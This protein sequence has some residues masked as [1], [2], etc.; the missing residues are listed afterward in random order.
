MA[1][2]VV[3]SLHQLV[4]RGPDSPTKSESCAVIH[5]LLAPPANPRTFRGRE[6][7]ASIR[8][9]VR[10][11]FPQGEIMEPENRLKREDLKRLGNY[12]ESRDDPDPEELSPKD[13]FQQVSN[14][15]LCMS[16]DLVDK[17][18]FW[19]KESLT[20]SEEDVKKRIPH[21]AKCLQRLKVA[22]LEFSDTEL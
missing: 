4:L 19:E 10:G 20:L 5:M 3:A 21:I 6:S 9:A 16:Y 17:I 8:M 14:I 2:P 22:Y 13:L 7:S 1:F 11:R 15:A 18:R 12:L